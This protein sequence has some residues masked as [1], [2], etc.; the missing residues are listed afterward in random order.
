[1]ANLAL[2]STIIL[3]A[4]LILVHIRRIHHLF[5]IRSYLSLL[6]DALQD[7]DGTVR[8]C[9]RGSVVELFTG[10]AVTD[11]ARADLKRE[12]TKKG[13]R[14]TIVDDVLFKVLSGG[15][16]ASTP[17]TLSEAGSEN[18]DQ[19]VPGG[20]SGYVP[21]S[22]TLIT[23]KRPG[24]DVPRN[25]LSKTSSF[26]SARDVSRPASRAAVASPVPGDVG[27][28]PSATGGGGGAEIKPVY[29]SRFMPIEKINVL[30]TDRRL[31]SSV[32]SLRAEIWKTS[33][34]PCSSILRYV[35]ARCFF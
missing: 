5:P 27:T 25:A 13:V 19:P 15:N 18:G 23:N 24:P 3:Q 34:L 29:V 1:M 11:G 14:K 35:C 12:M 31:G 26:A 10:P 30:V 17:V 32:R 21:P 33:L 8:E 28:G 20:T 4:I 16:G 6:V 9:A 7:P 2:H 22:I